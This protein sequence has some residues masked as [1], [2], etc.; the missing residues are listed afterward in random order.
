MLS[1]IKE[2]FSSDGCLR[3]MLKKDKHALAD[4]CVEPQQFIEVIAYH[5]VVIS[6][7][8][9]PHARALTEIDALE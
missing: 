1:S 6:I 4:Q 5:V 2:T 8:Y 3:A 9:C 7:S